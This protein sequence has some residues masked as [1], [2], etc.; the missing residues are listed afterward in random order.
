MI[1][2]TENPKSKLYKAAAEALMSLYDGESLYQF[3]AIGLMFSEYDLAKASEQ[4][5]E[6]NE[7]DLHA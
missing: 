1:H 6:E 5:I 2:K 4:T 7:N 3:E